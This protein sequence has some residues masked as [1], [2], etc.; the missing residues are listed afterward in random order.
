EQLASDTATAE[1]ADEHVHMGVLDFRHDPSRRSGHRAVCAVDLL[2]IAKQLQEAKTWREW[3]V[4]LV[5]TIE[6]DDCEKPNFVKF[7]HRAVA[8]W[9][10]CHFHWKQ[11]E[12]P[13]WLRQMCRVRVQHLGKMTRAVMVAKGYATSASMQ[14][15]SVKTSW[16][17]LI[18]QTLELD[19]QYDM[20]ESH[21]RRLYPEIAQRIN[22]WQ[23]FKN[24]LTRVNP[25]VWRDIDQFVS[26]KGISGDPFPQSWFRSR[27]LLLPAPTQSA[28]Q[29]FATAESQLLVFRRLLHTMGEI[30]DSRNLDLGDR[31]NL[32]TVCRDK[33][34]KE[35]ER[36][37][38]AA[39]ARSLLLAVASARKRTGF[40]Y[41]SLMSEFL[42]GMLDSE[43]SN[44]VDPSESGPYWRCIK[45]FDK[46][47]AALRAEEDVAQ[48]DKE[49]AATDLAEKPGL[50]A[51]AEQDAAAIARDKHTKSI[52]A[53]HARLRKELPAVLEEAQELV[54]KK[55]EKVGDA[56]RQS[57][58]QHWRLVQEKITAGACTTLMS[59]SSPSD[60]I[61]LWDATLVRVTVTLFQLAQKLI[62]SRGV[63]IV[64]S[65]VDHS[66]RSLD[67]EIVFANVVSTGS[68]YRRQILLKSGDGAIVVA[69]VF[70]HGC[71]TEDQPENRGG[72]TCS[73]VLAAPMLL[74]SLPP[75]QTAS[76]EKTKLYPA[77][78]PNR[79]AALPSE[80][81]K[82]WYEHVLKG[83]DLLKEKTCII[84]MDPGVGHVFQIVHEHMTKGGEAILTVQQP[85]FWAGFAHGVQAPRLR[86]VQEKLREK[87]QAATLKKLARTTS[88]TESTLE[89]LAMKIP[90]FEDGR[91]AEEDLSG[92]RIAAVV[93]KNAIVID[94]GKTDCKNV[95]V[96]EQ[97][98]AGAGVQAIT[99][100]ARLA[101]AREQLE[102][103]V[104][105]GRSLMLDEGYGLFAACDFRKGD[106]LF[107][108][109]GSSDMH[110]D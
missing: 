15:N 68:L 46:S 84:E 40:T 98:G 33:N 102:A 42:T 77:N 91:A 44:S 80:R 93:P 13:D 21:M 109:G 86:I 22:D 73:K 63:I 66:G 55:K 24:Q 25:E 97:S 45:A 64:L 51:T 108:A 34:L 75:S 59:D 69:H 72:N 10:L 83:L 23:C 9:A 106:L 28:S 43:I 96:P 57:A 41:E 94:S 16:L 58:G 82:Q 20:V 76:N 103:K 2:R 30:A 89:E 8:L 92:K 61:L 50:E 47:Q 29:P 87:Q 95:V 52:I 88:A 100:P 71:A 31:E 39:Y 35:D 78:S 37:K 11:G 12:L 81:P 54:A 36:C 101:L 18:L 6:G 110:W 90:P 99:L 32:Q 1:D 67:Q 26:Q 4:A 38:W 56:I 3:D 17:Q 107:K 105:V 74:D 48:A 79:H 60:I 7:H 14:E 19:L 62:G 65:D 104:V 5:C 85:L 53:W 49:L 27:Q 70:V